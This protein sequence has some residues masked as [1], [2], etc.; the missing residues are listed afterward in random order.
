MAV[1]KQLYINEKN[2]YTEWGIYMNS[3]ALSTLMTPPPSKE[4]VSNSYRDKDGKRVV[5]NNPRVDERDITLTFYLSAKDEEE[6]LERYASFCEELATGS[7]VIR[8]SFQP[9]V[10]YRC[11]YTSC[12]QFSEYNR[13]LATFTLKLNEPDPTNRGITDKYNEA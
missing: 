13:Q 7:L 9:G 3:S 2:A 8:T 11:T 6:F 12:T 5:K 10:Y 4:F 1:S